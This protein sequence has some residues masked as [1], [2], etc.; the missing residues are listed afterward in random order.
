MTLSGVP[1]ASSGP[2]LECPDNIE[3]PVA[4]P[5]VVRQPTNSTPT[6]A[7]APGPT[8]NTTSSSASSLEYFKLVATVAL[9]LLVLPV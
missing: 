5:T 1:T 4:S 3:V 6:M 8:P 2:E 9:L 7:K